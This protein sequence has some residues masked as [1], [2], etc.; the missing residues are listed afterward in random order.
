MV[1]GSTE[2]SFS[3]DKDLVYLK[4]GDAVKQN[5]SPVT[6]TTSEIT[7]VADITAPVYSSSVKWSHR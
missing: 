1:L 7:N 5:N 6:P 2:L 3:G 4:A